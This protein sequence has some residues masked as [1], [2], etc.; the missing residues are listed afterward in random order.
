MLKF[1]EEIKEILKLEVS[2]EDKIN[3]LGNLKTTK[4]DVSRMMMLSEEEVEEILKLEEGQEVSEIGNHFTDKNDENAVLSEFEA[5]ND[6]ICVVFEITD[7]EGY[8]LQY[9]DA[10]RLEEEFFKTMTED[11]MEEKG[12]FELIDKSVEDEV[13]I[14]LIDL[15][16]SDARY[17]KECE[18]ILDNNNVYEVEH[19]S[20]ER[21]E[22]GQITV[23]LNVR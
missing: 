19:I 23:E 11:E 13:Y 18:V 21:D 1:R 4:T 2:K 7:V 16:G 17:Y 5:L 9:L 20:D 3:A 10:E 8:K 14:E 6:G 12:I 22:L 15:L